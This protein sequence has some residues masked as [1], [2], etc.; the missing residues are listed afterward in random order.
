MEHCCYHC[1]P[2]FAKGS[3]LAVSELYH[4]EIWGKFFF[5]PQLS[6]GM[7]DERCGAKRSRNSTKFEAVRA[8]VGC[9]LVC[10]IDGL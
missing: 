6:L 9:H 5:S 7:L 4:S 8:N 1:G 3:Q 2:S 10:K